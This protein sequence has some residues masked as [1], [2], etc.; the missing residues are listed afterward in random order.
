MMDFTKI[1]KLTIGGVELKQLFVGGIQVWKSG[2]KNWVKYSTEADGKTI[3]NGGLG[4]MPGYRLNSRG[5]VKQATGANH[6]G[7]IPVNYG[8][9]IR[10]K[11]SADPVG[12]GANYFSFYDSSFTRL[13]TITLSNATVATYFSA[14]YTQ[15]ADGL[16]ML[17]LDTGKAG[18][19][20]QSI[21]N[22]AW[23]RISFGTCKTE[24]F[25]VTV[26]EEIE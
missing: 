11:G 17:T 19:S 23:F 9:V 7:Y 21:K 3:Y 8:E 14:T 15:Q 4:C 6:T 18:S 26:N 10:A 2:Y 5:E 25:V 1:K 16:Y 24:D 20:A 22:V 12:S 13:G